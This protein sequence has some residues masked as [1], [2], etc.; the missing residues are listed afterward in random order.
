MVHLKVIE[1]LDIMISYWSQ[2]GKSSILIESRLNIQKKKVKYNTQ[3]RAVSTIQG[4][5]LELLGKRSFFFLFFFLKF[6]IVTINV[7]EHKP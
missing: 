1:L 3:D 7:V 2:S 5:L 4:L 6:L